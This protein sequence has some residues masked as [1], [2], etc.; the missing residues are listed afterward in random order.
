LS[1]CNLTFIT[2]LVT[3]KYNGRPYTSLSSSRASEI[4][5]QLVI[6]Q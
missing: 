2:L 1:I 5:R 6:S 4:V 3:Y